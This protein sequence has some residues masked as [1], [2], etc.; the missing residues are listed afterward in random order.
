MTF[1]VNDKVFYEEHDKGQVFFIVGKVVSVF[2]DALFIEI[3]PQSI[4]GV[5]PESCSLIK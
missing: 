5:S 3:N 4:M 2:E 1:L